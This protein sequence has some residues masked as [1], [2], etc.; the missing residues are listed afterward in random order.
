MTSVAA[1]EKGIIIARFGSRA[2]VE[3]LDGKLI[4]CHIRKQLSH[5]V[6]G[7]R[8]QFQAS[9]KDA[10]VIVGIEPRQS[11][12]GRVDDRNRIKPLAANV[13]DIFIVLAFRPVPSTLLLD[14]YLVAAELL[15]LRPH[16][17]FNKCDLPNKKERQDLETQLAVYEQLEYPLM[18]ISCENKTGLKEL[19]KGMVDK[20]SVFVGQSGVG[21]SSI[22]SRLLPDIDIAVG[23]LSAGIEAGAHTTTTTR[24]YHLERGGD[25]IDSPGIRE[26]GLWHLA[27]EQIMQGFREIAQFSA[28]C[29][30]RNCTHMHE[31]HCKVREAHAAGL[32][33]HSRYQ[34]YCRLYT[35]H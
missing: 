31:P 3:T 12:L 10:H 13:T 22:I 9:L 18:W 6:C 30:F 14:S 1:T 15:K 7:D 21:K 8:V 24:L 35:G 25:V 27:K 2:D 4:R 32:V 20:T 23:A 28:E 16:I 33:A 5:A 29:K 19:E 34:N 11:E 17:I 26:F